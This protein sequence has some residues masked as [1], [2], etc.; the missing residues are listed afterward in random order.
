MIEHLAD[1]LGVV[2][3][4]DL[5][6]AGV[7][8]NAIKR[9]M[10]G[11]VLVRLRHGVYA[12][13]SLWS[14]AS[15]RQRHLMLARGVMTLYGDDVA[16]SHTSAALAYGAP[17]WQVPTDLVHLTNLFAAGERTQARVRHHR[18]TCR[19]QDLARM[20]GHWIT[21]PARTALDSASILD[22]DAAV[23][24]LDWFL[25]QRLTTTAELS[26]ILAGR[27]DWADHLGL[28]LKV[29]HARDGSDSVGETRTRLILGD[30]GLPAPVLQ[31]EVYDVDGR[32]AGIVDFAWPEHG[33]IVEFDGAEK[34]HRYRRPGETIEQ[35]VLREKRREDRIRELTGWVVIRISWADLA[36]PAA[37][38]ARLERYLR[39]AA[40]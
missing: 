12:L 39:A 26:M 40:A 13:T 37:L 6:A 5:V 17:D 9:L 18:G 2:L 24:V 19:V 8:D 36:N 23:C 30:L 15:G 27:Y 16:L 20:H 35:M 21:S 31:M 10:R 4:R 3:R 28:T 22:R 38:R 33:V 14:A 1:D 32:L 34:Y 7:N 25:R 11:G 29:D